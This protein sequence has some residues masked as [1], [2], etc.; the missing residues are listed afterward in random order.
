MQT[1]I[2]KTWIRDSSSLF[3]FRPPDKEYFM[4]ALYILPQ[5][6]ICCG[7]SWELPR[8]GN[9]HEYP[10]DL[11]SRIN[12]N[13]LHNTPFNWSYSNLDHFTDFIVIG[14]HMSQVW[15][16]FFNNGICT[17]SWS[18]QYGITTSLYLQQPN[19]KYFTLSTC[20]VTVAT[21][22]C[23][24]LFSDSLCC[25]KTN[26]SMTAYFFYHFF[27]WSPATAVTVFTHSG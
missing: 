2:L 7:N 24:P 21:L 22:D 14:S 9:S 26:I 10:Q 19:S 8:W 12:G 16:D 6:Y 5:Y 13:C 4:I 18:M 1:V 17:V 15:Y 11:F 20:R 27:D 23:S 3:W 25:F